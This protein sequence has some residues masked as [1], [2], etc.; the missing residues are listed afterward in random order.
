MSTTITYQR[1]EH[2]CSILRAIAEGKTIQFRVSS[3][4][5]WV[6]ATNGI[7]LYPCYSRYEY[8]VKPEPQYTFYRLWESTYGNVYSMSHKYKLTADDITQR[9]WA[10]SLITGS[11]CAEFKRWLGDWQEHVVSE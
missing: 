11:A 4:S 6:V 2:L 9:Q 5:E 8:R 10:V 1:A 3:G 7:G